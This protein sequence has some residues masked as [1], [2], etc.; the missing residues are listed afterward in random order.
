[1]F[2]IRGSS[3]FGLCRYS[4]AA[5][6]PTYRSYATR[7]FDPLRIL[8]CGSDEFSIASLKALHDYRLKH[9]EKISSIDVVCRPGKRVGR[10]LKKIRE[11]PIKEAAAALS[12]P[13]HEIDTFRG[14]TPPETPNGPINLIIAVS[15][16]LFVPPR[17]LNTAKYGGLN[18][19][20]SLLPDFRGPAPLH[21][22]LLAGRTKTGVTLQ[23]LD[24]KSFDHGTILAQ[25]PAP[26]FDIPNPESCTVPKLTSIVS[27]KGAQLLF[28]GIHNGLFVP[29]VQDAGWLSEEDSKNLIHAAKIMPE[30]R[31][32]DWANW[33]LVNFNRRNRVLGNL[34]SKAL[35]A[36]KPTEGAISF[37][38]KRVILTDVEEVDP[39]QGSETF[40]VVPGLPFTNTPHPVEPKKNRALYVFTKDG[41]ALRINHMKV[42]GE[43]VAEGLR[44]AIKAR[45]FGDR[46]FQSGGAEFT[47][48]RNPLA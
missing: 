47:P 48:F 39:P 1:M 31:H 44:A 12:L 41:K 45:M 38:Q 19:H 28:D 34:W 46:S 30:D 15:F 11:M 43:P 9:P 29:P 24:H 37:Q 32:V 4:A 42:E 6:W 22:T 10:G 7:S 13:V 21:H 16:G 17:I 5:R 35:V 18:V 14:W 25:S 23:T 3:A 26:G 8:F 36:S 2:V 27:V 40:A 33:D 20:P